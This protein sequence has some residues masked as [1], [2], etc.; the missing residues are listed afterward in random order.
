MALN[1]LIYSNCAGVVI[2]TML[3]THPL[4]KD[5]FHVLVVFNYE[6]LNKIEIREEHKTVLRNCDIFIYQPMNQSYDNSG[7]SISSMMSYFKKDCRILRMNY[8]RTRAFWY[9]GTCI[10]YTNFGNY[11]FHE[12]CG[13]HKDFAQIAN[14]PS[15]REEV[16]EFTNQIQLDSEKVRQFFESEA[17]KIKHLDEKSD[18]KMYDFFR[19]N[20][21][22]RILFFD[23]FHPS[24]IFMY[25]IFRQLVF[26]LL[27]VSLP[28]TDAEFL[29]LD[30]I[31]SNEMTL[32]TVPILPGIKKILEL[33]YDDVVPC[34]YPQHGITRV[35]MNAYDNYYIRLCEDNFQKYLEINH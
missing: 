13:I 10:P 16:V 18:V 6:N 1:V 27:G 24:N 2:Q 11:Y 3:E 7:Y 33:N 30:A 17:D 19:Q 12:T 22:H 4:T 5:R 29:N 9:E 15:T 23:C 32:W 21:K 20:Y 26:L 34:F 25:E 8:Y 14:R 31:K 28:E 35:Y